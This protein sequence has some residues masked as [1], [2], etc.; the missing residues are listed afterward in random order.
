MKSVVFST[1]GSLIILAAGQ[2]AFG[3]AFGEYGRTVNGAGQRHGQVAAKTPAG[4]ARGAKG[5]EVVQK[6]EDVGGR[7]VPSK[8]VVASKGAALYPRQDAEAEKIDRLSSGETLIP[9]LQ[10]NGGND[11]YMV[12]TQRGLIGWVKAAD[13]REEVANV[14]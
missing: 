1:I 5:K 14:P 7:P 9:L 2:A 6:V 10:S 11:W 3:Q 4:T 8:L 13:I 12:K